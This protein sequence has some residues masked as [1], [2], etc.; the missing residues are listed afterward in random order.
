MYKVCRQG[1]VRVKRI[2]ALLMKLEETYL[3][4]PSVRRFLILEK[5]AVYSLDKQYRVL[6]VTYSQQPRQKIQQDL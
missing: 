1:V 5:I 6:R 3:C 2:R 4:Q